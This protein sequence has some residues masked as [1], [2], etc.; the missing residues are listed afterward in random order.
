MTV[1]QTLRQAP[2]TLMEGALGERL[3]REYRLE[4]DSPAALAQLVYTE[5]GRA[6]LLALW[7]EY[8][9]IAEDA[10]LPFLATTPTRRANQ[11]R[12]RQ[13]GLGAE[14]IAENT[15]LLRQVQQ[16]ARGSMYLGGLMGC[17]GDAYT[18]AGWLPAGE[19][20]RFH[21]WQA[22]LFAKAQVD[23]LFAGILPVLEEAKGMARAME[24]TGLPYILSFTIQRDGRLIDGTAIDEAIR[25][26]DGWVSAPPLCYMA[27]CVH[28]AILWGALS[29]PFNRTDRVRRRFW[30]LQANAS[31]LPY[32]Q[33]DGAAET[34]GSPPE[35]LAAGMLRLREGFGLRIFGGCCG[36]DGRHL[37]AMATALTLAEQERNRPLGYG[38]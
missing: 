3:R 23:F 6:A 28:P 10:G 5:A 29:Q 21:R 20:H 19:A 8:R 25:Q 17:R 26:V 13:A 30:G 27:N 12:L 16:T 35:E 4:T 2:L 7:E 31:P 15:A 37:Q 18:G 38:E 32:C 1:A 33:L 11:E 14:A 34:C 24:E 9:S 36:T 22:Q